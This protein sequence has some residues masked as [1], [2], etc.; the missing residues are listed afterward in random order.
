MVQTRVPSTAEVR[1]ASVPFSPTPKCA[2][3]FPLFVTFHA[4]TA[5]VMVAASHHQ[6]TQ[7]VVVECRSFVLRLLVNPGSDVAS[8]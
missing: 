7:A 2:S 1:A 8:P 6:P 4:M 3:Y 5:S